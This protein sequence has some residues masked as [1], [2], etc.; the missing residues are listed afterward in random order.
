MAKPAAILDIGS[1]KI[2]CLVGSAVNADGISVHGVSVCPYSGYRAGEFESPQ[3]LHDAVVEAVQQA[4]Q[5]SRTRL[6]EVALAVPPPF[7]RL[8]TTEARIGI[9]SRSGKIT[10]QDIDD[11]ITESLKKARAK[12]FVLMHSTPVSFTVNGVVSGEVPEGVK[13]DEISG[14]VSHMYVREPF[15]KAM[16]ETLGSINVEI[17]M[18]VSSQLA[19]A[20]A[21]IPEKERVRPAVLLDVG[22]THTDV[23]IVE[24]AALTHSATIDVGGMHFA[25]DLSFGLDIPLDA[26]E[27]VK[28]RYVFGQDALSSTEI[29]RMPA[30]TKRVEHSVI[31]LIMEARANELVGLIRRT[32][33]KLGIGA[34]ANPT[35][36]LT[37]GGIAMV[38]GGSEFMRLALNLPVKRDIPFMPEMN[39]PNFTSA[40]GAMDFV[41]RALGGYYDDEPSGGVVD[42][43]RDLFTK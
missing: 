39:S 36:Y 26:A 16:E 14:V 12:D 4:E 37:G 43:L 30:G 25:N 10:A 21:I 41:L 2:V 5:D 27:Q 11:L 32:L 38:K 42:R 7:T 22:Y 9:H 15:V 1:S 23:A 35:T 20:L 3:S 13:A 40:F 31:E 29:I 17:S 34:E 6:R 19:E 8:V 24:N 18:C 33:S 28:R